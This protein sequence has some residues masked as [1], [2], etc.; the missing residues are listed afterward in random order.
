MKLQNEKRRTTLKG[1]AAFSALALVG[2]SLSAKATL[3]K[4]KNLILVS[5]SKEAQNILSKLEVS[6]S[7]VEVVDFIKNYTTSLNK[8]EKY[9]SKNHTVNVSGIFTYADFILLEESL[10]NKDFKI[11]S[12]IHH[13]ISK[14]EIKNIKFIS[15]LLTK[16]KEKI[17]V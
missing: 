13:E 17:D 15:F 4:D 10:K 6:T 9:L 2:N 3:E 12:E 1:M 7:N 16:N 14:D 5:S 8:I 11:K